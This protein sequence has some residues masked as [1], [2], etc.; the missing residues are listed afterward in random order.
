ML[1]DDE[2]YTAGEVA[3]FLKLKS[4]RVHELARLGILPH[5]RLGRQ[6]RFPGAQLRRFIE[7]GGRPLLGGWR[8][9]PS[10]AR[11][12]EAPRR[13]PVAAA[14]PERGL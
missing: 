12:T 11:N 1:N 4:D 5:F 8:H 14:Y 7:I 6:L 10:D 9:K 3:E 2:N 13:Q